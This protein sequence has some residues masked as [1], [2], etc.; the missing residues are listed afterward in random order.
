MIIWDLHNHTN[1]SDGTVEPKARIPQIIE[2]DPKNQ[3][4]WAVTD[5]DWFNSVF[6]EGARAEW[7]KALWATEI[8]AHSKE[9]NVSLHMACYL[10]QYSEGVA[11]ILAGIIEWRKTKVLWQTQKLRE[12]WFQID[13]NWFF[14]WIQSQGMSID[15]ATNWHIAH[16]IWQNKENRGIATALTNGVIQDIEWEQWQLLFMKECLRENGDFAE[17]GYF[18]APMY[19]PEISYLAQIIKKEDG[20]LSV[21]H[22]NFSFLK[23]NEIRYGAQSEQDGIEAFAK[24]LVPRLSEAWVINYEINA[25]ASPA[26]VE[27]LWDTI[28]RTGWLITYGSDNHGLEERDGNH[29]IFWIQNPLLT[30]E[31]VRRIRTI[32]YSYV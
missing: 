29:G 32:L 21:A 15:S 30:E 22:P 25:L 28:E 19:E 16:Y 9:I 17:V 11:A 18:K 4:F 2:L 7:I 10:P 26:W 31:M 14:W 23:H 12:V 6:V 1:A 24:H 20:I 3:G 13:D 5:H 27:V 8:S